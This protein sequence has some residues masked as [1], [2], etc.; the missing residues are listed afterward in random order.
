LVPS[1]RRCFDALGRNK[2]LRATASGNQDE[3]E[4]LGSCAS[5]TIA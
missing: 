3:E 4:A 2:R 5:V 1:T